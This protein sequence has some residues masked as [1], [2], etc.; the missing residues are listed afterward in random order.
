MK[1]IR[2]K[3]S[4]RR[5]AGIA[6]LTVIAAGGAAGTKAYLTDQEKSVNAMNPGI[7]E[8][9][10]TEEFP[11]PEIGEGENRYVKTVSV[12]NTGN[13]DCYVRV[14][15]DFDDEDIRESS[16]LS[17]DGETFYE[18]GEYR[19]HLPE[20]W[21]YADDERLDPYYYCTQPIA[22]GESTPVL[23]AEAETVFETAESV[24]PFD[25]SVYAESV[26]VS[27]RYG[28]PFEGDD[29]WLQAWCEYLEP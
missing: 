3:Q 28:E 14:F 2:M 4:I 9:R 21:V 10:I 13:T 25:I 19:Y 17:P 12:M 5:M 23:F 16:L 29:A 20:G 24:R 11:D 26:Q 27:D 18:A 7:N 15:A 6:A 22:P 1:K 8:I